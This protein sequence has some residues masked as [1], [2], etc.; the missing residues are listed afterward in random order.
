MLFELWENFGHSIGFIAGGIVVVG[1]IVVILSGYVKAPPDMAYI[2]SGMNKKPKIY[3]GRAGIKVPFF[4]RK[5]VLILKQITIDIKTNGYVP[6]KDFIGVDIDAVAKVRVNTE[7]AEGMALAMKNFLNMREDQIAMAL[8]DSL[9]GNMREIIGTVELRELN[10]DRKAFGD[11]VQDKAQ[12]DMNALGIKIISCN[13]Q[14]IEDQQNLI[15]ALGQDNMSKI[16]KDASIAKAKADRD[17][18]IERAKAEEEAKNAEANANMAIAEKEN[19]LA[20]KR[21]ELKVK[22]DVE[23]ARADAAYLIQEQEQ[24]KVIETAAVN[25]EIAKQEREVELRE[26]EAEVEEQRLVAE[27]KKKADADL[28]RRARDAEAKFVEEQRQADARKYNVEKEAEAAR[29]RADATLYAQEKEAE[30]IRAR[31]VAEADAIRARGVAEAEAILRKAEAMA[32]Y[33]D[34]A[35]LEMVVN[36]LP[37]IAREI[38]QPLGQIDKITIIGGGDDASGIGTIGGMVPQMLA[39]TNEV[40]KDVLGFDIT[41]QLRASTIEA[42]VKRDITLSGLPQGSESSSLADAF[43]ENPFE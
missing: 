36:K 25:A 10:T 9:Q 13:I 12:S 1:L 38:S 43:A 35:K 21:A 37:E 41:D 3:I 4:E 2:V 7:D 34:A 42:K 11:Q 26:R 15:N 27:I 19:A 16:Q 28:Y 8:T 31:G 22:E 5:D 30:G 24:R 29:L 32:E 20:I 18:A 17:V 40:S 14:K 23:R 39:K 6:T 33:K